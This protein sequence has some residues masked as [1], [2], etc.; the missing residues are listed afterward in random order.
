VRKSAYDLAR[1]AGTIMGSVTN[2]TGQ[3]PTRVAEKIY[4]ICGRLPLPG[5]NPLSS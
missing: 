3:E 1:R 5:E 2:N 4:E